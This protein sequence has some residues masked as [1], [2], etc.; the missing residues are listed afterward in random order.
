MNGHRHK[1]IPEL[2]FAAI[3]H[4][5][6]NPPP[7]DDAPPLSIFNL[8]IGIMIG[9]LQEKGAF[10]MHDAIAAANWIGGKESVEEV[11]KLI[12]NR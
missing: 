4:E 11:I 8:S 12:W 7:I 6:P 3:T 2:V 1:G 10:G 9:R 5:S